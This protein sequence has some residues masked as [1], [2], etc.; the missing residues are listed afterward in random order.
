[1]HSKSATPTTQTAKPLAVRRLGRF[2]ITRELG[3]GT[4][5]AVFVGHDPV[6]DRDV[7][8]KTF[9][10][11]LH[12]IERRQF[13][14]Q[15]INEARAAGRLSHPN[16]VTIFEASNEGAE[17]Y[18]AMELLQGSPLNQVLDAGHPFSFEDIASIIWRLADAL[19]HAHEHQVVHRD[20][21]PANIFLVDNDQ[22]KLVD[23]GIARTPNRLAQANNNEEAPT[24]LFRTNR[25]GTP[26]YMSPEQARG[27]AVDYRTDIYSLGAVMYEMLT[28]R[29]PFISRDTDKLLQMIAFKTPHKPHE[30][31][32]TVPVAL[33]RITMKAM[34]NSA[35]LRYQHAN[36][37]MQ[38]INRFLVD[39]RQVLRNQKTASVPHNRPHISRFAGNRSRL[40]AGITLIG[41][42]VTALLACLR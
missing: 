20:I 42:I 34:H 31:N 17:T 10:P 5:G 37:M 35:D 2:L 8:I 39:G 32:K 27:D 16:I 25:L 30:L 14:E 1:M 33:S 23:F 15:F 36:E 22:P 40:I 13:D 24:T 41:V 28:G 19:A 29:K 3:R 7:A 26:N 11:K 4:L 18:I 38:E 21:K 12:P 9:H 6:I